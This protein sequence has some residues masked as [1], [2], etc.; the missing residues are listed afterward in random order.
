MRSHFICDIYILFQN[1]HRKY[2]ILHIFASITAIITKLGVKFYIFEVKES[3]ISSNAGS[4]V[5]LKKK[6]SMFKPFFL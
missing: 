4:G 6:L 2:T 1:G 3:N 5:I